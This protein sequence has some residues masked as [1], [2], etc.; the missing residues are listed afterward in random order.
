MNYNGHVLTTKVSHLLGGNRLW[1]NLERDGLRQV[2]DAQMMC[3]PKSWCKACQDGTPTI[4]KGFRSAGHDFLRSFLVCAVFRSCRL[5]I[6]LN[7]CRSVNTFHVTVRSKEVIGTIGSSALL[8]PEHQGDLSRSEILWI[9]TGSNKS[10]VTILDYVPDKPV[11]EP[12]EQFRSRLQ[13]N[14]STGFLRVDRIKP[15]DQGVYNFEVDER[16]TTTIELLLF[17]ELSKTLIRSYSAPG[18]TIQL[19][20]EVDGNPQKYEWLRNGEKISQHHLLINGNRSLVIL[21]DLTGECGTYT[22]VA[23]NPVGSTQANYTINLPGA[24]G[25]DSIIIIA[26]ITGLLSSLVSHSGFLLL[27]WLEKKSNQVFQSLIICNILSVVATFVA[28]ISW[29][30]IKGAAF[31]SVVALCIVSA[32]FLAIITTIAIPKFSCFFS[33]RFQGKK[34]SQP[35]IDF[36]GFIIFPILITILKEEI[37]QN[38]QSCHTSIL[39][40]SIPI[41]LSVSCVIIMSVFLATYRCKYYKKENENIEVRQ[42]DNEESTEF[43]IS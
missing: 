29:V 34:G 24:S 21:T 27:S 20:C 8:D 35:S 28:L 19:T 37:Q 33:G 9:F 30:A 13:F 2:S 10:P 17:Y 4:P 16:R 32:L 7:C 42:E 41:A 12:N 26:S 38:Y 6:A 18:Y 36:S 3:A 15:E 40:W 31:I 39:T 22:C 43:S 1:P 11:E 5:C 23:T 14:A 25:E